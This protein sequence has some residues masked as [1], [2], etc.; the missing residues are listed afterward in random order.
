MRAM[1]KEQI[2][3]IPGRRSSLRT[4]LQVR[5]AKAVGA[6]SG[7]PVPSFGSH[8]PADCHPA[9]VRTGEVGP[10]ANEGVRQRKGKSGTK[11]GKILVFLDLTSE[12][13]GAGTPRQYKARA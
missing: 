11:K 7:P 4:G 9:E 13:L 1:K 8:W 6:T 10:G 12:S 5:K 3:T 2:N